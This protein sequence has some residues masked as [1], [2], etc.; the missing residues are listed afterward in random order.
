MGAPSP[1]VPATRTLGTTR[2]I[3][4]APEVTSPPGR[5]GLAGDAYAMPGEAPGTR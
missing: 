4:L 1:A 3:Q 2:A 5:R